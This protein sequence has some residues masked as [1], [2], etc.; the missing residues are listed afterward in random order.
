MKK[1]VLE[2]IV[3]GQCIKFSKGFSS[4]N[5]A[6][7]YVFDYFEKCYKYSLCVN[8]EYPIHGNKHNIEYVC[9][10]NNRFRIARETL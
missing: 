1:Y 6:I 8:E 2:A 9:D 5:S 4:R 3:D 7:N 10:Y